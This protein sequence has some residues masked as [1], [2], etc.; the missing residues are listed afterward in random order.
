MLI[1]NFARLVCKSEGLRKEVNIAQVSEILRVINR[2]TNGVL[3][4]FIRKAKAEDVK[5]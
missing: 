1:S 3:Y 2:L 4:N 5:A